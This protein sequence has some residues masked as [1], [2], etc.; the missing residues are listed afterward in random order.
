MK[1]LLVDDSNTV[2]KSM[3]KIARDN[4]YKYVEAA[5]GAEALSALRKHGNSINLVVLDWNMPTMD[6]YEALVRI[7]ANKDFGQVPVLMATSHGVQEDVVKAIKA[8]ANDYLVK[9]Y[10]PEALLA[11]IKRVTG[12]AQAEEA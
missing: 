12:T 6:G 10:T 2:R 11:K 1:I 4:G 9:P 8:G 5:T 7:R 3:A